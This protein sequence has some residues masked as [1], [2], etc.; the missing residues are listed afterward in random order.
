[1]KIPNVC[2]FV[3]S[4]LAQGEKYSLAVK[5]IRNRLKTFKI[6]QNDTISFHNDTK[7]AQNVIKI[8]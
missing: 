1:M 3:K 6:M 8:K 7:L 5:N 4:K 2:N